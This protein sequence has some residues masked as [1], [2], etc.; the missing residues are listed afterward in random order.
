MAPRCPQP[1]VGV[2]HVV[3]LYDVASI[4]VGAALIGGGAAA[5]ALHRAGSAGKT[6]GWTVMACAAVGSV[7]VV[8]AAGKKILSSR[9]PVQGWRVILP[10]LIEFIAILVVP[11]VG[12]F[13][14]QLL[15]AG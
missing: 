10:Y 2:A 15:L 5:P 12:Y 8:R 9:E 1:T 11:I 4:L 6:V 13:V 7:L 3:S 14:I